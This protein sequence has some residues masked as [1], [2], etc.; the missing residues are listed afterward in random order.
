MGKRAFQTPSSMRRE[1]LDEPLRILREDLGATDPSH[2][3]WTLD[4]LVAVKG[5]A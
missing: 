3:P 2:V 4:F 5:R 1:D